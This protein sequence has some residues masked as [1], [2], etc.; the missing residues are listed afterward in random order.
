MGILIRGITFKPLLAI[1]IVMLIGSFYGN[2]KKT[3]NEPETPKKIDGTFEIIYE[4]VLPIISPN[5]PDTWGIA[6]IWH[7]SLGG[8]NSGNGVYL[9]DNKWK[10]DVYLTFSRTA[11]SIYFIDMKVTKEYEGVARKISM[12][13]K[14]K[15]EWTELVCIVTNPNHEG[16]AAEFIADNLG[17]HNPCNK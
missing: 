3:P 13:L 9:G 7:P 12:R 6:S 1:F 4:R 11:Y 14:G 5:N 16:E 8:R 17:V 2:C 15:S 10:S